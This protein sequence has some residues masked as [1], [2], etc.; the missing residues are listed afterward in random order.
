MALKSADNVLARS[1][2]ELLHGKGVEALGQCLEVISLQV[3]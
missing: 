1:P 2:F 3:E